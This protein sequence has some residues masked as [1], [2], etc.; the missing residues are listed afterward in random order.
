[1]LNSANNLLQNQNTKQQ[2]AKNPSI[3]FNLN[4]YKQNK[5]LHNPKM[6]IITPTSLPISQQKQISDGFVL[7]KPCEGES[8]MIGTFF[9]LA[10]THQRVDKIQFLLHMHRLKR[11]QA[12]KTHPQ[13]GASNQTPP[14]HPQNPDEAPDTP[15]FCV[16]NIKVFILNI[17]ILILLY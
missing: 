9:A 16:I 7:A 15:R 11:R 1:M 10:K 8:P 6:P 13:G 2:S 14:P 4:I 3:N 17:I 5:P 12:Y